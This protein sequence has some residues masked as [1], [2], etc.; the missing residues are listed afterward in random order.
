MKNV[1]QGQELVPKSDPSQNPTNQQK[2]Q[3]IVSETF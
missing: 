1:N 2:L 3:Y